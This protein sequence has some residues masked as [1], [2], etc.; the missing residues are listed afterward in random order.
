RAFF[1]WIA[2]QINYKLSYCHIDKITLYGF[3]SIGFHVGSIDQLF[4]FAP[5]FQITPFGF[6]YGKRHCISV[7]IGYGVH[8]IITCGYHYNFNSKK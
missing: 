7:E 6:K 1:Y 5:A 3:I 2:P 4:G 8:G